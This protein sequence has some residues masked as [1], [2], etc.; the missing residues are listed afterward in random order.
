MPR[1]LP[2]TLG[3]VI[4][5]VGVSHFAFRLAEPRYTP[6]L[7]D[8]GRDL[9]A[10]QAVIEG[11][12]PYQS[13]GDILEA[14]PHVDV[15]EPFDEGW[16]A[17]SPVAIAVARLSYHV[18]GESA[19]DW[20]RTAIM[21]SGGAL[22]LISMLPVAG[23]PSAAC[24]LTIS[25]ALGLG[26]G[27]EDDVAWV[28]G[29]SIVSLLVGISIYS[30][31]RGY[32]R[33]SRLVLG[34]CIAWKPWLAP[35]ALF[36]P[37][38]RHPMKDVVAVG[39]TAAIL[40]VMALPAIGGVGALGDWI[41]AALP[42]NTAQYVQFPWNLS[43][44]GPPLGVGLSTIVGVVLIVALASRVGTG[45]H[46]R[47]SLGS[48]SMLV[49]LPLVWTHYWVALHGALSYRMGR[50]G[51]FFAAGLLLMASPLVGGNAPALR[52]G[53]FI[54]LIMVGVA[55]VTEARGELGRIAEDSH[56]LEAAA[57]RA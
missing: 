18:A 43:V 28:Q 34:I 2:V 10:A 53:S 23:G 50:S 33:L 26:V 42:A 8:F 3:V 48:A 5:V 25:G 1:W 14:L 4:A 12:S 19:E 29:A 46:T 47:T 56:E 35:L 38:S 40:T 21:V 57:G 54:A 9:I 39:A 17:H 36:L 6:A 15:R 16:I 22:I 41:T 24:R 49:F 37:G 30:Y 7:S 20:M 55:W 52:T 11:L 13:L 51:W 44:T 27:L 45:S 32:P 31:S